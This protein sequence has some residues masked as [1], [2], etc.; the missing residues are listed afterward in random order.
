VFADTDAKGVAARVANIPGAWIQANYLV[1]D[2][3][4][5]RIFAGAFFAPRGGLG[6]EIVVLDGGSLRELE[7]FPTPK[8]FI[9][10]AAG[11]DGHL[12]ATTLHAGSIMAIDAARPHRVREV[13][14]LGVELTQVLVA[15]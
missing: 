13:S 7:A 15:P 2:S 9:N 11:H 3:L 6:E 8:K 12:Y 14:G 4:T 10:I 1:S 5:E